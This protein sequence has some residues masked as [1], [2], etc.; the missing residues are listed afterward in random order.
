M[1]GIAIPQR[2]FR[3]ETYPVDMDDNTL[4]LLDFGNAVFSFAYGTAAGNVVPSFGQPSFFGT[5]GEIVGTKTERTA[6]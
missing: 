5:Q 4:I 3:G 2:S 1:S 6:H